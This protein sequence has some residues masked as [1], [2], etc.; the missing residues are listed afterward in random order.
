MWSIW[1]LRHHLLKHITHC[2][3]TMTC[4]I[5][6]YV[7]HYMHIL[8]VRVCV[9]V[10]CV[11]VCLCVCVCVYIPKWHV[12]HWQTN[13]NLQWMKRIHLSL[14]YIHFNHTTFFSISIFFMPDNTLCPT[15]PATQY[16]GMISYWEKENDIIAWTIY[17]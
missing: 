4:I 1:T 10:V 2:V 11:C 16:P 14:H 17:E 6:G 12:L 7:L 5:C 13:I 15:V 8:Y 3:I 9:C